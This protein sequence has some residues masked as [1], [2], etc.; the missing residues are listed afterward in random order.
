MSTLA[1][2]QKKLIH[3]FADG[4]DEPREGPVDDA[5]PAADDLIETPPSDRP[6]PKVSPDAF[7]WVQRHWLNGAGLMAGAA[8]LLAGYAGGPMAL[9]G[10]LGIIVLAIT[11]AIVAR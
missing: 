5:P 7:H 3:S 8:L 6:V 2:L 10:A 9:V 11:A 4:H 1:N